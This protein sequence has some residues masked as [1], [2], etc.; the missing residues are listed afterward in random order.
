MPKLSKAPVFYVVAQV[1]YSPVLKLE[2]MVPELQERLRKAGFP[3]YRLLKRGQLEVQLNA[4]AVDSS[5]AIVKQVESVHHI[6]SSRDQTESF[7][8]SVD[9]IAYQTVEYDTIDEFKEKF[10]RGIAAVKEIIAPDSF[11]RIGLRFLDAVVPPYELEVGDYIKPQFLGLQDSLED[12]WLANYVFSEASVSR[13]NRHT[14]VRAL[15]KIAQLAFP[16]D[17]APT[18]PPMPERFASVTGAHTLLDSDASI[19]AE[20]GK[21][22]NF[23]MDTILNCL[24]NLKTDIRDTFHAVVTE[25]ALEDWK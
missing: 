1:T 22:Q 8:L 6:F 9:N 10:S 14:K 3:G 7:V 24:G 21:A 17:L 4:N 15:T 20:E 5:E 13:E 2:S 18:A 12:N 25:R 11:T 19:T 23:E 16:P